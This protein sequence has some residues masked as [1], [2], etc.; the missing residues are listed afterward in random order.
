[1]EI[2]TGASLSLINKETLYKLGKD[3]DTSQKPK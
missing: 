3:K 1:M 2:D